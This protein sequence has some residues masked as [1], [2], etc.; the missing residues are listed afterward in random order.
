MLSKDQFPNQDVFSEKLITLLEALSKV[1][2]RNPSISVQAT[3]SLELLRRI[4][5]HDEIFQYVGADLVKKEA[6]KKDQNG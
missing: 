3:V 1:N 4:L 6:K 2:K 5:V